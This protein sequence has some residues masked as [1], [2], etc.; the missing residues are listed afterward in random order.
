MKRGKVLSFFPYSQLLFKL[1]NMVLANVLILYSTYTQLMQKQCEELW[2]I[3][4]VFYFMQD[5]TLWNLES[6]SGSDTEAGNEMVEIYAHYSLHKNLKWLCHVFEHMCLVCKDWGANLSRS[7]SNSGTRP[8]CCHALHSA[9]PAICS[10][11]GQFDGS[12]K[13]SHPKSGNWI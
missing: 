7:N 5:P 2:L 8:P 12:L 1:L 4:V 3:S 11:E 9:S 6:T 13:F 10:S